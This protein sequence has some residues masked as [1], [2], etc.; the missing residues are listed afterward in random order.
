[1]EDKRAQTLQALSTYIASQKELLARTHSDIERLHELQ[2]KASSNPTTVVDKLAEEVGRSSVL[3]S[4][5][6]SDLGKAE[7]ELPLHIDWSTYDHHE[8]RQTILDPIFQQLD[9]SWNPEVIE[10]PKV[11]AS[12]AEIKR[13]FERDKI[14]ELKQRKITTSSGLT[15]SSSRVPIGPGVFIR[16]DVEDESMDVD[17][18]LD[19]TTPLLTKPTII[20]PPLTVL[21]RKASR[22]RR[23]TSKIQMDGGGGGGDL[24][25]DNLA[26]EPLPKPRRKP[27]SAKNDL[28]PDPPAKPSL[29]KRNRGSDKPKPETY[30]QAW[31]VSEQ[32]LLERLLD[33]IP[34]GEKNRW[35]KISLAMDNKRT[36]RQVASRVQKYFEKLKRFGVG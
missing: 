10:A 26:S 1:M 22:V 16:R 6:G 21:N 13:D 24:D 14:R 5:F 28:A 4:E 12:H 8:A 29:G 31:S 2:K 34:E 36:P 32:H 35:K 20:I 9:L 7:P 27:S 11:H 23:P 25:C 17:I 15:V 33:E 30:N 19:D 3:S 18:S